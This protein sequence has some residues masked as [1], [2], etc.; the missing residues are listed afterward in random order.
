M[1]NLDCP[2]PQELKLITVAKALKTIPVNR[3][4][5]YRKLQKGELPSYRFGR[6][7]LVDIGECLAAMRMEGKKHET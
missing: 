4:A 5:F 2:T 6:R 1:E 3:E 7:I